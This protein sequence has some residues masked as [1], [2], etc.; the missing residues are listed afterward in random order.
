MRTTPPLVLRARTAAEPEPDPTPILVTH[1]AI[2]RDLRRLADC[3]G[4]LAGNPV[5]PDRASAIRR[6][7]AALLAQIRAH[8]DGEENILWPVI[9]ATAGQSADLTPLTD[10][11]RAIEAAGGRARRALARF[12]GGPDTP[13]ELCASV[14]ALRDMLDEHIADEE[15]QILPAL[16]RYVSAEAYQWCE[17]QIYRKAGPSDLRFTLP[18]L[19]RHASRDE[20]PG[21]LAAA[22]W[23]ALMILTAT[24]PAYTRLERRAFG[25][26]HWRD[27]YAQP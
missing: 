21:L 13:G 22:G 27:G 4:A 14:G 5:P 7:A 17:M 9:A 8:H 23:P 12:G 1:R 6:Y 18:W 26:H 24:R 20:L 15:Q 16:Q 3:L 19:A 25:R 11:H 2:L 10:D